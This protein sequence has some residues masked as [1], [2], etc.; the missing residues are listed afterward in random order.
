MFPLLSSFSCIR[1]GLSPSRFLTQIKCSSLSLSAHTY[2]LLR[3]THPPPPS[4]IPLH[5]ICDIIM[6]TRSAALNGANRRRRL[7]LR[8][9][10]T[11]SVTLHV[12]GEDGVM[13]R[14]RDRE[15]ES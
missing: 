3:F 7:E 6:V 8:E 13:D 12:D 1:N 10:I 5:L 15:R 2:T 4:S 9:E 14:L 11:K